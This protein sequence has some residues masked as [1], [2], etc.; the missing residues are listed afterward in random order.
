V[1]FHRG[2]KPY[3]FFDGRAVLTT[4]IPFALC[5]AWALRQTV[6]RF[7]RTGWIAQTAL[8]RP[9]LARGAKLAWPFAV[10][11][12]ALAALPYPDSLRG[13]RDRQTRRIGQAIQQ[14]STHEW[15]SGADIFVTPSTYIRYALLLPSHLRDRV[16]IAVDEHAP[17]WWRTAAV[18]IVRRH[19]PL[20][21][22]DRAYLLVT[23]RQLRAEPEYWDYGVT[24]PGH[25]LGE[26]QRREPLLRIVQYADRS[27]GPLR[28]DVPHKGV[29]LL[30]LG[31]E[32]KGTG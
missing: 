15:Q 7:A 19:Q 28:R 21:P 29:V 22:P 13:F 6:D 23:P 3:P 16:R 11:A 1:G 4:C 27:I 8:R 24:L 5:L 30:L 20:P 9:N 2:S 18:D 25:A 10:A 32:R 31:P 17:P 26:W 14:M 12:V